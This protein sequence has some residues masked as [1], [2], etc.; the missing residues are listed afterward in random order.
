M[1]VHIFVLPVLICPP[2]IPLFLASF[3]NIPFSYLLFQI[4]LLF[5]SV[6]FT[7]DSHFFFYLPIY[8]YLSLLLKYPSLTIS[9]HSLVR[10]LMFRPLSNLISNPLFIHQSQSILVLLFALAFTFAS[11]FFLYSLRFSSF[12]LSLVSP[13]STYSSPDLYNALTEHAGLP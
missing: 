4:H 9:S 12:L 10:L 1:H 2:L 3:I 8:L 6:S 11:Q 7:S 5:L 13:L